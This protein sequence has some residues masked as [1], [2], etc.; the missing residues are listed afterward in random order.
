DGISE[1]VWEYRIGGYQVLDRWLQDRAGRALTSDEI[2]AFCRTATALGK[3][4]EAQRRIEEVYEAVEE[5]AGGTI[6][7]A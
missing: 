6:A 3:T 7:Q 2:Q 4:V 1:Q 5:G